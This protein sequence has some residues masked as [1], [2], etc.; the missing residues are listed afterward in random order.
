MG[1]SG[2]VWTGFAAGHMLGNLT[3][4][5]G[6][7]MYNSYGHA[8]VSNKPLLWGTEAILILALLTHVIMGILLTKQNRQAREQ[9]YAMP[10]NGNKAAEFASKSMIYHGIALLGFIIWH[11]LTFKF[12]EHYEVTYDGVLMRDLFTLMVEKFNQPLYV[13]GYVLLMGTVGVHLSHGFSSS[14]QSLGF[15]HPKYSPMLRKASIAFA[16]VVAVG[17]LS[18][19]IYI[20]L[21]H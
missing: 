18:Q 2:L 19:P 17:F 6:P 14:F 10:T 3:M 16:S 7:E 11:L 1:I 21:V 20:Y 8:I 12:G 9:K 5:G 13:V 15:N 4:F